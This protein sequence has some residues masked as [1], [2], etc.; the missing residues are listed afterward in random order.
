MFNKNIKKKIVL[1][2]ECMLELRQSALEVMHTS[3]AGDTYNT[4]VYLKRAFVHQ[5]VRFATV[6]GEDKISQ[7]MTQAFISEGINT[8]LVYRHNEKHPG[9]YLIQTDKSGERSFI[10]WRENS[11]ATTLMDCVD[12]AFVQALCTADLVFFS[13][14]SLGILKAETRPAFWQ[15]L[16]KLKQAGV[17]IA[18]DPNYRARLWKSEDDARQQFN[19]AFAASSIVLPGIEDFSMLYGLKDLK[20]IVAFC[21]PFNIQEL[22]IK[23]GPNSV[24]IYTEDSEF[25]LPIEA[26]KNVVDTTSAGDS[27]N[28]VYIGARLQGFDIKQAIELA[29]KAAGL[30][31]QFPGAIIPNENFSALITEQLLALEH[32]SI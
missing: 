24:F 26:V 6:L 9:V 4:A 7:Q 32:Q 30:V 16:E 29:A 25:S 22:I 31:I 18:F 1:I 3:Y 17:K 20:Q 8:D 19:L 10:Y 28:G 11:A 23:N 27:F 13:G 21:Q 5:Q 15:M 2:G 14:I 12:D